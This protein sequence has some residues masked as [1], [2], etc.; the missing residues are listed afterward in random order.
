LVLI[1]LGLIGFGL[2]DLLRWSPGPASVSRAVGAVIVGIL[3]TVAVAALS[4]ASSG[5]VLAVAAVSLVVLGLWVGFDY[6]QL[7]AA[8]G[9]P[10]AWMAAVLAVLFALGGSVD[11]ISGPLERW[12]GQLGF[13]FVATIA[14][15]QFVL[16]LGA[17]LFMTASGNRVVRL[18]LDAAGISWQR[19]ESAHPGGRVLGPLERLIVFAIVL[20]GDL[21][22]AAIVITGKGLLRF[23]EIRDESRDPGPDAATE[24]FLIGTF[25]SLVIAA[26]LG[27]LVLASS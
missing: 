25:T 5:Q 23:P 24:Y 1:A 15:D 17:V 8:P 3:G 18:T 22:A 12:Y 9:L 11:P 7:K 27:I 20:A 14:I 6:S 19:S 2:A 16:G 21:A 13:G 4:G 26:M 10:L